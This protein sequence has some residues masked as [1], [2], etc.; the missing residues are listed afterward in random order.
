MVPWWDV[1]IHAVR[2]GAQVS[3]Y[4]RWSDLIAVVHGHQVI[5]T[6]SIGHMQGDSGHE[7][8]TMEQVSIEATVLSQALLVV[9]ATGLLPLGPHSLQ[10]DA[11]W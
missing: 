3:S 4:L 2:G 10:R 6:H 7:G 5:V 11:C 8:G 9:G 1:S